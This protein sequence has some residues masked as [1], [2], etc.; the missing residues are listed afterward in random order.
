[1]LFV[2]PFSKG[3][4]SRLCFD[5]TRVSQLSKLLFGACLKINFCSTIH[6]NI[7]VFISAPVGYAQRSNERIVSAI[8]LP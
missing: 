7:K 1:M 5:Y 2:I 4:N 6:L 3:G 8:E